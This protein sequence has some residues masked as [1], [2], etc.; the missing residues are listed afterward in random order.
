MSRNKGSRSLTKVS[1]SVRPVQSKADLAAF[2]DLPFRLYSDDP[3][4]VPPLKD[5]VHGLITPGKNP[6]FGHGEAQ[7]FLAERD[8]QVVGRISAHID[9][10]ALTQPVEQGMGPGT[11]NWGLF[12]AEDAARARR[13]VP[14]F[15]TVDPN[16]D[17]PAILKEFVSNFHPRMV[18]LTGTVAQIDDVAQRY[19][20]AFMRDKPNADGGY[21]VN[22]ARM[23]VLYGPQGEPIAMMPQGNDPKAF[24]A[25]LNRWV[26]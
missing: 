17:T 20:I 19:G 25:E 14:I 26:R 4:W 6:W 8:G 2:V 23:I 22:H 24:V 13:V 12:E 21:L 3:S 7:L 11:G 5:E 16:R 9:H 10:L 15:I 18:G 1:L